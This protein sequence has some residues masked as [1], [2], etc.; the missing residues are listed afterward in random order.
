MAG[1]CPVKPVV[2]QDCGPGSCVVAASEKMA[3]AT[4]LQELFKTSCIMCVCVSGSCGWMEWDNGGMWIAWGCG[5]HT[6]G[7]GG[8]RISRP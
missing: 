6:P 4:V 8:S 2:S 5:S 7:V 1:I 3:K